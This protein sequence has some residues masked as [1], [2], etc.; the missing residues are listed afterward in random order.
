[1][2]KIENSVLCAH[3]AV[4]EDILHLLWECEVDKNFC[5]NVSNWINQS[6]VPSAN[7]EVTEKL[8][9]LGMD[10]NCIL[11][12]VTDLILLLA[13]YYTYISELRET[14]PSVQGFKYIIKQKYATEVCES[15]CKNMYETEERWQNYKPLTM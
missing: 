9:I 8:E 11:D 4:E 12:P 1:M 15:N 6:T 10:G 5:Q 3:C 14:V 7:A 2:C 13:K